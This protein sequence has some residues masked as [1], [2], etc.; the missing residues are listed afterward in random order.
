MALKPQVLNGWPPGGWSYFQ[1]ETNWHAPDPLQNTFDQQAQNISDMRKK[2]PAK[3]LPFD[4]A[5]CAADLEAYTEA[6]LAKTYSRSGM[7]KFQVLTAAEQEAKKKVSNAMPFVRSVLKGAAAVVGVD[8]TALEEWLGAGGKPVSQETANSRASVC[9]GCK[10]NKKA[11]WLEAVTIPA[12]KALRGYLGLKHGM[13]LKTLHDSDIGSC[14]VCDCVLELKVWAPIEHV[15]DNTTP[16]TM[17][18]HKEA[19]ADCWVVKES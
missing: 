13:N 1:P 7:Q 9:V 5:T 3:S 15:R 11:G 2:N 12:A 6:R 17:E 4:K 14:S 10:A 16:E 18:K 8:S 19:N